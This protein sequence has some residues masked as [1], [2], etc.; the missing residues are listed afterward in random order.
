M[1]DDL[2]HA[3]VQ[4]VTSMQAVYRMFDKYGQLVYIGVTG[5]LGRR[6]ASHAEKRWFPQVVQITLTWFPDREAAER[7]ERAAIDAEQ[8]RIN[9]AGRKAKTPPVAMRR[10]SQAPDGPVTLAEAVGLRIL[11]CTLHAARKAAQRPG[12]PSPVGLRGTA[13]LYDV[14]ALCAFRTRRSDDGQ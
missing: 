9:I 8:P 6:L 3:A 1:I 13:K 4:H 5:D 11:H 14:D 2:E 10:L 12:F 7:A